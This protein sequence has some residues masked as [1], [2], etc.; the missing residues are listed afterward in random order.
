MTARSFFRELSSDYSWANVAEHHVSLN[1]R[2]CDLV[3]HATALPFRFFAALARARWR[4]AGRLLGQF[5]ATAMTGGLLVLLPVGAVFF[6]EDVPD[7][8][9]FGIGGLI[10]VVLLA[11]IPTR[12]E[13]IAEVRRVMTFPRLFILATATQVTVFVLARALPGPVHHPTWVVAGVSYATIWSFLGGLLLGAAADF[14]NSIV[15]VASTGSSLVKFVGIPYTVNAVVNE[16][17]GTATGAPMSTERRHTR[18]EQGVL[19]SLVRS[20]VVLLVLTRVV[21]ALRPRRS[22]G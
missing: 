6:T 8:L 9:W 20:A 15:T 13:R 19:I 16:G 5:V 4:E 17:T 7:R 12:V 11:E 10:W 22:D 3:W 14:L 18:G 2:L 21:Q 1:V